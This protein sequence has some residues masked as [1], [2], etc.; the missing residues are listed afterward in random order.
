V[1]GKTGPLLENQI[2]TVE[3]PILIGQTETFQSAGWQ[4][5]SK[6]SRQKGAAWE[7]EAHPEGPQAAP[8]KTKT[9]SKPAPRPKA[10]KEAKVSK[11]PLIPATPV[12][13][14]DLQKA[15]QEK[16]ASSSSS[17]RSRGTSRLTI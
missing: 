7:A 5:R 9:P 8:A 2:P 11:L 3:E 15:I 10:V 17:P 1:R 13:P 14:Q 4:S 16:F 6:E 12:T